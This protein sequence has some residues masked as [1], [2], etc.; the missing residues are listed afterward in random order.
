MNSDLKQYNTLLHDIKLRVRQGQ[1]RANLKANAEMLAAY[2]DIGKMIHQRQ[3]IEGWGAGV[4]PRLAK[5][6]KNQLSEIKGFSVRNISRMVT[7]YFEY[8]E[9]TFLPLPVAKMYSVEYQVN[10]LFSVTWTHHIILIEKIK[11]MSIRLWYMKQ[12]II[13][14]WSKETLL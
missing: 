8:K 9:I 13:N 11:D 4:I 5:D 7:F 6:L 1:L 2:W 14:G 12:I 3:Q 10:D